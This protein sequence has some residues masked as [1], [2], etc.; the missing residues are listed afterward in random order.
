VRRF[1]LLAASRWSSTSPRIIRS[2]RARP[3]AALDRGILTTAG[4]AAAVR[5]AAPSRV[6]VRALLRRAGIAAG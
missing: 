2:K 6:D 3:R 4:F 5:A 1:V